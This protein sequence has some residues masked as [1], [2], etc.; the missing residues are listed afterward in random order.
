[1]SAAAREPL[2]NVRGVPQDRASTPLV[3]IGVP[4]YNGARFLPQALDSLLGQRLPNLELIISDNASS[5]DTEAICRAYAAKDARVRYFRQTVNIGAPQNWNF[6]A[7]QARSKYFKW[8][9]GNDFCPPDMLEKCVAVMEAE[10]DVVLCHGRTCLIDEETGRRE[11]YTRDIA[12][13]EDL[14]HERFKT[15]YRTLALNNAQSGLIRAEALQRTRYDRSYPGGDVVLMAE[16]A[17]QGRFVLLPDVLLY[18]RMGR[19]TFSSLLTAAEMQAFFDPAAKRGIGFWYLRLHLDFLVTALR[20]SISL[21]EKL[22]TLIL[23]L[24]HAVWDRGKL[25]AELRDRLVGARHA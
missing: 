16:L 14:P 6:V 8:S 11:E 19:G 10:S 18:R 12:I 9:S 15:L 25:W 20:A 22:R 3:S 4:V 24:R 23:V 7:K 13:I 21:P 1:M 5:D 2:T 17:L